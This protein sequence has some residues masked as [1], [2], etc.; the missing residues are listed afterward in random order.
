MAPPLDQGRPRPLP[1]PLRSVRGVLPDAGPLY[2]MPGTWHA[3]DRTHH[4]HV[5]VDTLDAA[6]SWC[7]AQLE[8]AVAWG[9][10]PNPFAPEAP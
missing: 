7:A 9:H 4:A 6:K 1:Q 3:T 8:P 10:R 2:G 5:M